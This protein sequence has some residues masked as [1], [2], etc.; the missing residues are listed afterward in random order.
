ME[1]FLLL[2]SDHVVGRCNDLGEIPNLLRIVE[3]AAE[4]SYA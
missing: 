1:L 3:E 4:R 2:R